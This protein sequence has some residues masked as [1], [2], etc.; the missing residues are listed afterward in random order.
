VGWGF[1]EGGGGVVDNPN[2]ELVF[3]Y[4]PPVVGKLTV[5]RELERSTGFPV[6]HNHL[7]VDAVAPVFPFG[8]KPFAEL[9]EAMWLS[10]I[11]RAAVEGL[12][13]LIFTFAPEH[14]VERG[15]ADRLQ[16]V[17]GNAGGRVLFVELVCP[18]PEIERRICDDSRAAFGKLQSVEIYRQARDSGA[19]ESHV[20]PRDGTAID[21]SE[22]SPAEAALEIAG[23][24]QRARG[25]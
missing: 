2:M 20:L 16:R 5:A 24:L 9:R 7:V 6:F 4:G 18:E 10:V 15:F 14:T 23:R 3:I 21:T 22:L 11:G 17:V 19:F 1:N 12:E 8:S 13:G 25:V